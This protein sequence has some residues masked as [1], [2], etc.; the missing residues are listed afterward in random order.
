MQSGNQAAYTGEINNERKI[1]RMPNSEKQHK[2]R[3]REISFDLRGCE[4]DAS[5]IVAKG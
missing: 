5:S 1:E 4:S 2:H 3:R